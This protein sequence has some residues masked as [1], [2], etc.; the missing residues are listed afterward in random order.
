MERLAQ[1]FREQARR[2]QSDPEVPPPPT[3]NRD[4][5]RRWSVQFHWQARLAVRDAEQE[6]I[7][8]QEMARQIEAQAREDA[9]LLHTVGAGAL[10]VAATM[11][12]TLVDSQ[13]GQIKVPVR[14]RDVPAIA[15]CGIDCLA[16]ASGT[17][18]DGT[19]DPY[20]THRQAKEG[21]C[22]PSGNLT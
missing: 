7:R 14:A 18:L 8:R 1:Q 6:E 9:K 21:G 15:K 2:A 4:S 5:L 13:T 3:V 16:A 10:G 12:N 11:L 20:A 22:Q 17:P 19:A